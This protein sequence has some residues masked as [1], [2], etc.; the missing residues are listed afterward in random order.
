M[1]QYETDWNIDIEKD[2]DTAVNIDDYD[3]DNPSTSVPPDDVAVNGRFPSVVS[4]TQQTSGKR[5]TRGPYKKPASSTNVSESIDAD[6]RLPGSK[7][8]LSAFP[9][10]SDWAKT[11]VA[12]KL[13]GEFYPFSLSSW[14]KWSTGKRYKTKKERLRFEKEGPPY[15]SDG[16]LDYSESTFE[17][18]LLR[19]AMMTVRS[20]RP[21]L[22]PICS[23]SRSTFPTS[24]D[25]DI[26]F[27]TRDA[28]HTIT[29]SFDIRIL[30]TST[31]TF[32]GS[33]FNV[34]SAHNQPSPKLW[35]LSL[36]KSWNTPCCNI[37]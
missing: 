36:P 26:P 7:D 18:Y 19:V 17:H 28:T 11:M 23:C 34:F 13:K 15:L 22:S 1:I 2:D 6:G 20:G 3:D 30:Y 27:F 25:P 35:P 29:N 16:S 10:C 12:L 5:S 33:S 37:P 32:A 21:L 24:F 8:G 9:P 4:Q 31:R 14:L